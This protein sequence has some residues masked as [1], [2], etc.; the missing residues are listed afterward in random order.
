VTCRKHQPLQ[1][2]EESLEA[3]FAATPAGL[4]DGDWRGG[5]VGCLLTT[6]NC[7][8]LPSQRGYRKQCME[9][10]DRETEEQVIQY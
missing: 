7:Q 6:Q 9:G 3:G 8:A 5:E 1:G 10:G 2:G 4:R